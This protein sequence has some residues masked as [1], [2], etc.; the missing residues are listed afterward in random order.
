MVDKPYVSP[1]APIDPDN[2][3]VRPGT[4]TLGGFGRRGQW[5]H[6]VVDLKN[7][8]DPKDKGVFEGTTTIRLNHVKPDD[9]SQTTFTTSYLQNF[10]VAPQTEKPY[11]FSIFCPELGWG[12]NGRLQADIVTPGGRTYTRDFTLYDLDQKNEQLIVV[13]SDQPG[14]FKYLGPRQKNR[15]EPDLMD[16]KEETGRQIAS[17]SPSELP[18]RW[19]DLTLAS[20]IIIDGPPAG[21]LSAAQWD[22]LKTYA[23]AGGK[24][25]IMAGKDPNRLKG[26]IEDLAGIVVRNSAELPS[27]DQFETKFPASAKDSALD[28]R[29]P[30]IEVS[31]PGAG[32]VR[33][34]SKTQIVEYAAKSYGAG[35]VA[36]IPFSL[37]DR[38]FEGWPERFTIPM[39]LIKAEK[40]LFA[41]NEDD[42]DGTENVPGTF[43]KN[44]P[45]YPYQQKRQMKQLGLATLRNALDLSFSADTPV[46]I[47][48]PRT[49]LWFMIVYLLCAV[50]LNYV[51]FLIIRKREAAW[52]MVPFWAL[53]FT[54]AAYYIGYSGK[55][56]AVT[57]NEVSVIE[58][59][60]GQN[61]GVGRT[62]MGVYAPRRADYQI[63][64]PALA[65]SGDE[66]YETDAAPSPLI[67]TET[68]A[69]RDY[70]DYPYMQI[71]E[72]GGGM[73]IEQILIQNRSTRRFEIQHRA[74]L[75]GGLDL[76][77]VNA[78]SETAEHPNVTAR[79]SVKRVG[80]RV[81][82]IE[83]PDF[84]G[85]VFSS[86]PSHAGEDALTKRKWVEE[87][88][89][90]YKDDR[91]VVIALNQGRVDVARSNV[92]VIQT[93]QVGRV[94]H[95]P[96]FI[97]NGNYME[98]AGDN[99]SRNLNPGQVWDSSQDATNWQPMNDA[100]IERFTERFRLAG[101]QGKY[102]QDRATAVAQYLK[103]HMKQYV[104]GVFVAWMDGPSLP[105]E[106]GVA[107][108]KVE[109]PF[110]DGITLLVVPATA[111]NRG[112]ASYRMDDPKTLYATAYSPEDRSS[113]EWKATGR[114]LI[115]IKTP[116]QGAGKCVYLRLKFDRDYGQY[117]YKNKAAQLAF[118]LTNKSTRNTTPFNGELVVS[119]RMDGARGP[120]DRFKQLD[121][122][123]PIGGL[124]SG[125]SHKIKLNK[126]Q[127][128]STEL[129]TGSSIILKIQPAADEGTSVP[130]NL[131][132]EKVELRIVDR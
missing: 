83:H 116:V 89:V 117:V 47:Q 49:V 65:P 50:P 69:T 5:A 124:A 20:L 78:A 63:N 52:L 109:E 8:T 59:G 24:I 43:N 96:V 9:F 18:T 100:F 90:I 102:T 25:L 64:F 91:H 74:W 131:V 13:V 123:T 127:F 120:A 37:S 17:V 80:Q 101:P 48:A 93:A 2:D 130:D 66:V 119:A 125:V 21:G 11:H 39:N 114:D 107:G 115:P 77:L 28:M 4:S 112:S 3:H 99:G 113:G 35:M 16:A 81:K 67:N 53:V 14:T 19:H 34:N 110:L 45:R 33:R 6:V 88:S 38:M 79:N 61:T 106:V 32:I 111:T 84:D 1:N 36:F 86:G 70:S 97:K 42:S 55:T 23:Q 85:I 57:V 87:G 108:A 40:N 15:D 44:Y 104:A 56:G 41:I 75:G 105:V 51:I 31:A 72:G 29:V 76:K 118:T 98:F 132:I 26:A 62:F 95:M 103:E 71:R 68:L 94:L 46:E 126:I 60:A 92:A 128:T 27:L 12:G 10:Q 122:P 58:A 121:E 7:T 54:I 30:I 73:K 129:F 22:A 82:L